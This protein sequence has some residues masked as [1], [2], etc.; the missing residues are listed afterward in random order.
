[1]THT[2][3][4]ITEVLYCWCQEPK[5]GKMIGCDNDFCEYEHRSMV[6]VISLFLC[7]K[8]RG[9]ASTSGFTILVSETTRKCEYQWFHYSCVRNH[10]EMRVPVVSLFLCRKP[11]GNAS[12]SGFT[13]LVSETTRKCEYQWFHYSCVGNH[14]EMRVPVVSLFLCRKPRGKWYCS[15]ECRSTGEN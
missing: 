2:S 14:E 15:E 8:P 6:R 5:Y 7:R 4:R 13:I 1:M 11:R 12:T 10:E 3:L 9:N